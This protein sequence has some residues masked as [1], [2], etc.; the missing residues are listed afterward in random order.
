MTKAGC[1]VRAD[2]SRDAGFG[3]VPERLEKRRNEKIL[4]ENPKMCDNLI[5]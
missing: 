5:C 1:E 4:G 3:R 2:S